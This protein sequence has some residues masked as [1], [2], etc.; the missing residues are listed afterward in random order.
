MSTCEH[1]TCVMCLVRERDR[2]AF[3]LQQE[4]NRNAQ[5]E[6]ALQK[7]EV[8]LAESRRELSEAK[9]RVG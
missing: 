9:M 6:R 1:D 4:R 2:T 8:E 7:L 5:L 3:Q